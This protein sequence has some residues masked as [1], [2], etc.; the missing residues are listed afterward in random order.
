[1]LTY[2]SP[3]FV[4]SYTGINITS[5]SNIFDGKL[6]EDF[7][8]IPASPGKR[9]ECRIIIFDL[10][11]ALLKMVGLDV[12]PRISPRSIMALSSPFSNCLRWI[13]SIQR[14]WPSDV[15]FSIVSDMVL[16]ALVS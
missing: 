3:P 2:P 16:H 11:I 10:A 5:R 1:M 15:S 4:S 13:L 6:P 8:R 9:R 12:M 14:D 7:F